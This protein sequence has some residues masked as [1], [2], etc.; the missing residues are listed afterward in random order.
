MFRISHNRTVESVIPE[1]TKFDGVFDQKY[2]VT[3]VRIL[4]GAGQS[5]QT[6]KRSCH[7]ILEA[8]NPR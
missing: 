4:H 6:S 5:I 2:V 1:G 7:T 8:L 3:A